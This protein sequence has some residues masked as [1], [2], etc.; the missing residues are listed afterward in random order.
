MTE[1]LYYLTVFCFPFLQTLLSVT[2]CQFLCLMHSEA[3]KPKHWSLE[4]KKFCCRAMEGKWV[5]HAQKTWDSPTPPKSFSKAFF[6]KATWG[7]AIPGYVITLCTILIGWCWGNKVVSQVL[8]LSI[9]KCQKIWGT[10]SWSSS[11]SFIPLGSG[12]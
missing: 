9:L 4:Q 7:R 11:S 8:T 1:T 12:F 2:K 5:A 10:C 6:F 3:N